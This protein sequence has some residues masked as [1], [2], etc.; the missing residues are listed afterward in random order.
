M[1]LES[2]DNE[3]RQIV[4]K[5][6]RKHAAVLPLLHLAQEKA[7][8]VTPEAEAWVAGW[9]DTPVVHV[10]EVVTFYTLFRRKP[11]GRTHIRYCTGT[12]CMLL[13]GTKGLNH[14]K[15]KPG[16][17]DG[18]VSVEEV[19]CLCNCEAAPM[20]QVGDEYV[21]NLTEKKIDEI[22]ENLK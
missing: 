20:M 18:T 16:L 3:A 9:T 12:T 5:Y 22:L 11:A 4:N 13:G 8:H 2:L 19:E 10:R 6:D 1:N 15:K 7:G 17:A 21:G 14:L